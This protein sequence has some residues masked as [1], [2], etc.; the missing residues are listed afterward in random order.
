MGVSWIGTK[1]PDH[2]KANVLVDGDLRATVDLYAPER[3]FSVALYSTNLPQGP[4]EIII[5]VDHSKNDRSV[6]REVRI[7]AFDV[8]SIPGLV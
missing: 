4:H 8:D 5:R 6:G 1:G 7:D 3:A 2:G